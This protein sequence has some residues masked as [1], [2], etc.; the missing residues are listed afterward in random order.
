MGAASIKILLLA[1]ILHLGATASHAQQPGDDPAKLQYIEHFKSVAVSEMH[2]SGVPASIT[3]A[4]G[5]LESR[6]GRSPLAT[7]G[8]NHFGIKCHGW[9]GRTMNVD[10]D[11]LGECFRV[12]DSPEESFADHSDFLRGRDRYSSLF[13]LDPTDYKGWA[14]G[15]KKAGYA[16]SPTYAPQLIKII[17]DYSLYRF[18]SA[19]GL[20]EAPS[21]IEEPVVAGPE[22]T[23]RLTISLKREMYSRNGVPFVYAEEGETYSSI[24]ACYDLFM[25]E[26]LGF[27]DLK[28][29][30]PL[31]PGT[32]VYLQAKKNN[33]AKGLSAHVVENTGESLRDIAQRYG[34]KLK[35]LLKKNKISALYVPKEGDMLFISGRGVKKSILQ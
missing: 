27:N 26:I 15:L 31:L 29:D 16:T 1:W 8:N 14:T 13:L 5:I 19:E 34:I 23:G 35:A 24:A 6:S 2:R 28:K 7:E 20:P 17:E 33:A 21:I 30:E 18:D 3:L 10:D 4:Q 12:Y 22:I 25:R 32:I 9:T 11:A